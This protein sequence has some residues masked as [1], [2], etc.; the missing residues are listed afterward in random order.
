MT[1]VKEL[2]ASKITRE[3]LDKYLGLIGWEIRAFGADSW[4]IVNHY[5]KPTNFMFWQDYR[6]KAS[7]PIESLILDTISAGQGRSKPFGGGGA[8]Y[9]THGG[10][11]LNLTKAKI[12]VWGF[13]DHYEAVGI[14][15]EGGFIS[16]YN[17]R[18]NKNEPK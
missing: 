9:E 12:K 16:F 8:W 3:R 13:G 4:R 7:T 15:F 17:H 2:T 10:M 1:K 18:D 6:A 5:G 14:V 11:Q